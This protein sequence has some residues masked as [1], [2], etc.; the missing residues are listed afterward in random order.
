[1]S[2][3][4]GQI[5]GMNHDEEGDMLAVDQELSSVTPDSF[6][7]LVLPGGVGQSGHLAD[8]AAARRVRSPFRAGRQADRVNVPRTLDA[9]RGGR[10]SRKAHDL[11]AVASHRPEGRCDL[12]GQFGR[13]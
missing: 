8:D 13:G 10:R 2:L 4:G 12:A 9:D 6:D 5:Q 11:M 3:K 1:M 7:T